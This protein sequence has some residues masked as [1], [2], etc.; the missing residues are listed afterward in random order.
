VGRGNENRDECLLRCHWQTD[1]RNLRG[2]NRQTPL[3]VKYRGTGWRRP[4]A[5][6]SGVR[7]KDRT[8]LKKP[9]L[10]T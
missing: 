6:G 7:E 8:G 2:G 5:S 9:L 3:R 1:G 4:M 10:Y